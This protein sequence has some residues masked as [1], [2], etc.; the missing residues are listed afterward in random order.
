MA[1]TLKELWDETR[2]VLHGRSGI[3]DGIV[4]PL[5][6]VLVNLGG[7]VTVAAVAGLAT[8]GVITTVRLAARRPLRFALS[9]LAGT[10]LAAVLAVRSGRAETYFLPGLVSGAATTLLLVVSVAVRRP[11]V[12]LTS[13]MTRGWPIEWY[14]HDRVRPA[15]TA[16]T[17]LWAG[18]FGARTAAQTSIYLDGDVETLG[19]V[20]ILTGWPAL[21]VLLMATYLVGR[22]RL[23]ALAGPSV[24]EFR[25]GDPPPW[26]G[27]DR[28]F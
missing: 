18:F 21:I 22:R 13:W 20:R 4:P 5:V 6:F 10:A 12:A 19:T 27:Q 2:A 23:A 28:G 8:A 25:R 16:V 17:W 9:G 26:S 11:A 3:A 1:G 14:W 24:E 15:Y 7:N